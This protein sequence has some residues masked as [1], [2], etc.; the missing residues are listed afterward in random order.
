MLKSAYNFCWLLL[1]LKKTW[2]YMKTS[3]SSP[4]T[5]DCNIVKTC[6]ISISCYVIIA[7]YKMPIVRYPRTLAMLLNQLSKQ[8]S[9]Q[10]TSLT[11]SFVYKLVESTLLYYLTSFKNL[12]CPPVNGRCCSQMSGY[13]WELC[14]SGPL[15]ADI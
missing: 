13:L 10:Q 3:I 4:I 8:R 1:P 2:H 14:L 6:Y 7:I 15:T 11:Y 5:I 9:Y 12:V